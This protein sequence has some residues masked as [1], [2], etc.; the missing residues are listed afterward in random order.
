M[1]NKLPKN[2]WII[3]VRSDKGVKR[4][5]KILMKNGQEIEHHWVDWKDYV[6]KDLIN[7]TKKASEEHAEYGV[8][9]N[10]INDGIELGEISKGDTLEVAVPMY[11][12]TIGT[13]HTHPNTSNKEI[14]HKQNRFSDED[15][16][17]DINEGMDVSA[18][19]VN[20]KIIYYEMHNLDDKTLDKINQYKQIPA[21]YAKK[22]TVLHQIKNDINN[23]NLSVIQ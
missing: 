13:F 4:P 17:F 15:I 6:K 23:N 12:E 1:N 11:E 3:T 20:G 19:G 10:A 14:G 5:I 2:G 8:A 21:K 16:E 9:L 7:L 18:L 22:R